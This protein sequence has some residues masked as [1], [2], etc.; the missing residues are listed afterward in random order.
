MNLKL[1]YGRITMNDLECVIDLFLD[2]D[3][4]NNLIEELDINLDEMKMYHDK[5]YC[6]GV[7]TTKI[8]STVRNYIKDLCIEQYGYKT[9]NKAMG[10]KLY[11][12]VKN[13][14]YN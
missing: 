2:I 11:K 13:C 9:I 3:Y 10:N 8:A 1:I 5:R 14:L 12:L 6:T 7:V 4:I